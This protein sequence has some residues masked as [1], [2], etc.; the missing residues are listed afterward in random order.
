M[1]REVEGVVETKAEREREKG[2]GGGG[3][4]GGG[5]GGGGGGGEARQEHVGEDGVREQEEKR[6]EQESEDRASSPFYSE[7]RTPGCCQVTVGLSLAEMS[8]SIRSPC[9]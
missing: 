7:S 5:G 2:G 1:G 6:R 8:L 9:S 3:G 4:R